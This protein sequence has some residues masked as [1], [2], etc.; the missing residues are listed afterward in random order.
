M[1]TKDGLSVG[2]RSD[3]Y[4]EVLPDRRVSVRSAI[5]SSLAKGSEFAKLEVT[6][7]LV[8]ERADTR[9]AVA[10]TTVVATACGAQLWRKTFSAKITI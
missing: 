3:T 10:K 2:T 1:R 6:T 4:V 7:S 9:D 8:T 5:V